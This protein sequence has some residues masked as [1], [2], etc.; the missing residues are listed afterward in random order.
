MDESQH[1]DTELTTVIE[2]IR[3]TGQALHDAA[4]KATASVRDLEASLASARA[5]SGVSVPCG[6]RDMHLGYGRICGTRCLTVRHGDAGGKSWN[7]CSLQEKLQAFPYVDDLIRA[8]LDKMQD[9]AGCILLAT[10]PE[11]PVRESDHGSE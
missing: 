7:Q 2:R 3:V 10:A 9:V 8:I 1:S 5:I 11:A 4:D 6:D